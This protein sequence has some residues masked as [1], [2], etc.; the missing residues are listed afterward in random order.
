MNTKWGHPNFSYCSC[1]INKLGMKRLFLFCRCGLQTLLPCGKPYWQCSSLG[2]CWCMLM[3]R[4]SVGPICLFL[5]MILVACVYFFVYVCIACIFVH[6]S[7]A[8]ILSKRI[9]VQFLFRF[10]FS[11]RTERPKD[12]VPEEVASCK[13]NN[14]V[15]D[16]HTDDIH[17]REGKQLLI[18]VYL[19]ILFISGGKRVWNLEV[20]KVNS[21]PDSSWRAREGG[22]NHT[23]S[24]QT[25]TKFPKPTAL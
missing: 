10:A 15:S 6:A 3:L 7:L 19:Y 13:H 8:K 14:S 1:S 11:A 9:D 16:E 2:Y 23:F 22:K 4:T 21:L 20:R 12:W 18:A 25:D 24:Y 5:C 17:S